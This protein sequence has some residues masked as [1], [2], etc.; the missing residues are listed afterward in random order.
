[1]HFHLSR[2]APCPYLAGQ[3]EQKI[4]TMM[5]GDDAADILLNSKLNQF[6]FRRSQ[7]MIYRPACPACLACTPVRIAVKHFTLTRSLR[8]IARRNADL[9]ASLE[10]VSHA[11]SY[12][13]LFLAYQRARHEYSDMTRLPEAEF[14]AM[15]Q[16]GSASAF[17]LTL[18]NNAGHILAAML[19]DAVHNGIS[20]V[21]S[22]FDPAH[23]AR[24]LGT[25]L[26]LSLVNTAREKAVDY[27]YL[28]YWVKD[29]NKMNY[30]ARF[31]ALEKLGN[32]GWEIFMP[33][34]TA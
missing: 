18:K 34:K 13:E 9:T 15:M 25:A 23:G 3:A 19:V 16:K 21:Y 31:P 7:T 17:L 10:P 26:I 2:P 6:G 12:Y 22:F 32:N 8:R 27:I 33:P 20:A 1:M 29:S 5:I 4:F 14:L 30:K 24:S 11:A 28:G